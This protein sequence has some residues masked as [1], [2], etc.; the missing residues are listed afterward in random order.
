M[1]SVAIR[2]YQTKLQQSVAD[3]R[4]YQA[5]VA[6]VVALSNLILSGFVFELDRMGFL[7]SLCYGLDLAL[8]K[9]GSTAGSFSFRKICR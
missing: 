2:T 9:Y 1:N 6:A 7:L 4:L 3:F 5:V 8:K